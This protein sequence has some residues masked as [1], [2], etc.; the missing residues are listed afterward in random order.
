MDKRQA[1]RLG[2]LFLPFISMSR[3]ADVLRF[4][5]T[6]RMMK[7]P[8]K[9]VC[10]HGHYYQPPRENAW[11]EAIEQ[12]DSASPFHDWNERINFECYAPNA[13]ARILNQAGYITK[14]V[15]IYER[16]SFNM[17]PTLLSW[18]EHADPATYRSILEADRL[19]MLRYEGHGSALAQVYNHIIMPLANDRDRRTQIRWGIRDFSH[20]FGR[21]P[22]GIWL[23][24]TAVDMATLEAL[25]D[26]GIKFTVL[27]PRQA[28]AVRKIGAE[29]WQEVGGAI[30]PRQAYRC[31]LSGGKEI[32]LFFYDGN[33]SQAVAFEGLLND[34][35]YFAHRILS[36]LDRN[37]KPQLAHIA[38]DGESYGHHHRKGEMALADCLDF[39]ETH[40]DAQLTNYGQYLANFPPQWEVQIYENSSWSC[41]HGVE[42]WRSDCGCNSGGRPGW[43]QHWRAPLRETLDWLRDQLAPIYEQEAAKLTV[44]P[45]VVRDAYIALILDRSEAQIEHFFSQYAPK[46]NDAA[47]RTQLLRLLEMQRH[48]LLMY[49]S[50]G[51]FFDEISGLETDQ[52]LQYANRAIHYAQQ[53]GGVSLHEEFIKRLEKA[54]SNVYKS[55][56]ESYRK[57]VM[58]ARIDLERVAMHYAVASIFEPAAEQLQVFNYLVENEVFEKL[59]AGEQHLVFGRVSIQSRLT[60]SRRHFTFAALHLGQQNII[61]NISP[62]LT[63]ERYD[64]L[65]LQLSEAFRLPDLGLVIGI[66]QDFFGPERYSIQH[67]FHDEQRKVLLKITH[68]SLEQAELS[69]RDIFNNNYQLMTSMLHAKIPLPQP[70]QTTIEFVLNRDLHIFLRSPEFSLRELQRLTNE[71]K[72]WQ[73]PFSD[74]A[75]LQLAAGERLFEEVKRLEGNELSLN[76]LHKL[77]RILELLA[78]LG[79]QVELWKSQ[80]VFFS[81]LSSYQLNK[82]QFETE[83]WQDAFAK[84]GQLLKVNVT[85]IKRMELTTA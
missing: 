22:E 15:N 43:R 54:P 28:K 49:T 40:S 9:F 19:S 82:L 6:E 83:E 20:R 59:A 37:D 55:G 1:F 63:R 41:V 61:G 4:F 74:L 68:K 7:K 30:D 52:I 42:R 3:R 53:V 24:E 35:K 64:Q 18:M 79:I 76:R 16:I 45:W 80:N 57:N 11:L 25:A 36:T 39:I 8:Q 31:Q 70:Y 84:L 5:T 72:K 2:K 71:F 65:A 44:A 60:L 33:V 50:C 26:E 27:A 62:N 51:W 85:E 69:F 34:G 38:T 78:E 21:A 58:P 73:A 66:M 32:A 67:L 81:L 17:G 48:C 14:I 23:A 46:V 12:Q 29:S 13:A 10:I 75:T 47:G 77:I 56:A